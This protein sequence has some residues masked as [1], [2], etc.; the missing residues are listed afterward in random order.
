MPKIK[1]K[2]GLAKRFRLTKKGKLKRQRA[3]RGHLLAKKSRKRKRQ[4][5][6]AGLVSTTD[7]KAIKALLSY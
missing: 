7:K 5:R 2:K 1:T 4:L 6:K 3:G